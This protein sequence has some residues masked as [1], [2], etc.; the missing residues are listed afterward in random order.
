[1]NFNWPYSIAIRASDGTA[2]IADTW[3]HRVVVYNVSTKQPVATYGGKGG[4]LGRFLYPSGIAISPVNGHI[5]VADTNSNRIVELSDSGGGNGITWVRAYY[6]GLSSP[7]GVAVDSKGHIIVADAGHNQVVIVN[8]DG[9][10]ATKF[11]GG[12][13]AP[14]NVA[15]DASDQIYVADTYN[16]RVMKYAAFG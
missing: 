6:P 4:G 11:D 16:D 7:Q 9:T 3:N 1:T 2:W 5:F 12:F 15:V 13:Y 14:Q 10:V 8:A